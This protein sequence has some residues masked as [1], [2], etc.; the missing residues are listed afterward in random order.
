ME[1]IQII[2]TELGSTMQKDRAKYCQIESSPTPSDYVVLH[3]PPWCFSCRDIVEHR[4]YL[5]M[6]SDGEVRTSWI[7]TTL[8]TLL[9]ILVAF[10]CTIGFVETEW[11]VRENVTVREETILQYD[12]TSLVY[13]TGMFNVCYRDLRKA[14]LH[15]HR[16]GIAKFPSNAWQG[17]CLLYGAGCVLQGCSVFVLALS[18]LKEGP[19]RKI[20]AQMVSHMHVV[21]GLFQTVS[22]FLYPLILDTHVGQLHCGGDAR[23][24]VPDQCRVGWAYVAATSGTLLTFYCPF[25]AY[26]STYRDFRRSRCLEKNLV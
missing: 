23:A 14:T 1:H 3:T 15:C 12:G 2:Y 9:S 4:L 26:F 21:G 17:T 18:L 10:T 20:A 13:T 24:Y 22:L 5:P 19:T 6:S 11:F 16:F 7:V 25:L 8:W